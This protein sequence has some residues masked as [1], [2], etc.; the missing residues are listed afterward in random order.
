MKQHP[1]SSAFPA[2]P[3]DQ[4]ESL[5]DS[6]SNIGVQEPIT[7][8]EGMVLDGW[9]RF[10][11][12]NEVGAQCPTVELGD[13][14]P[15]DFVIAKNKAR[16][17]ITASQLA[18]AVVAVYGWRSVGRPNVAP[19]ATLTKTNAEL[20]ELAGTSVRTIRQAKTVESKATPEVK[21]AVKAGVMSVKKAAETVNP[22]KA[23]EHEERDVADESASFI[24]ELADENET[25]RARLAVGVMD[26]TDEE[27]REAAETITHLRQRVK[28]LEAEVI[29]LRASRDGFQREA[30]EL[31]KQ[32]KM[33][34]KELKKARAAA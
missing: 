1:L 13:V 14:D 31:R 10:T 21:E 12:A 20:A 33:N 25:L 23:S 11:A 9:H 27:K 17:H 24:A 32:I 28:S 34:E 18:A 30:A 15:Q 29:A 19:G 6:I 4:F 22:P 8:F 2:M 3:D 7:V 26:G 16:R 5:K